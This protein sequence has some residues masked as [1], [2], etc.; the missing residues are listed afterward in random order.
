MLT[1][2]YYEVIVE[3]YRLVEEGEDWPSSQTRGRLAFLETDDADPEDPMS[4]R[5]LTLLTV[6]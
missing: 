2:P 4:Y 3:I 5:L 1:E 6:L